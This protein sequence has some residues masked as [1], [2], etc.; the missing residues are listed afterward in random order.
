MKCPHC[1]ALC[2]ADDAICYHCRTA[3]PAASGGPAKGRMPV[4]QR[5]MLISMCLAAAAAQVLLPRSTPGRIDIGHCVQVG[6]FCAV[7]CPI[8]YVLGMLFVGGKHA[9]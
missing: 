4:P 9:A 1:H 8:G 2:S 7:A 5:V 6:A 3:L